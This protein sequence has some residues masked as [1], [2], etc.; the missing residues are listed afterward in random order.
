MSKTKHLI[1]LNLAIVFLSVIPLFAKLI[2]QPAYIIIYARAIISSIVLFI[3][4]FL[5]KIS[6]KLV[7]KN[8]FYQIIL[9]GVLFCLHWVTFFLS[10]QLA[11][12]AIAVLTLFTFPIIVAIL[13]PLIIKSSFRK[14]DLVFTVLLFGGVFLLVPEFDYKDSLF[15]GTA[16]GFVSAILY[17]L[18]NILSKKYFQKDSGITVMF[19]QLCITAIILMPF[20][21]ISFTTV[22]RSDIYYLLLLS[23]I[24]ST[25]GHTL[26]VRSLLV[27][28]ATKV[29]ISSSWQPVSS[30]I[31]ASIFL[32][33][34]PSLK[35]I[36]GGIIIISIVILDIWYSKLVESPIKQSILR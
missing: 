22:S 17:S 32:D 19:Y 4:M 28:K 14:V 8:A 34:T 12:V 3:V 23:I 6:F 25:I 31:L 29:A 33:E 27:F 13:E 21:D 9:T 30:I 5:F 7:N 26:F 11:N 20:S 24:F 10:V 15:L 18:R 35:T 36:I 2:H 1:E 16:S